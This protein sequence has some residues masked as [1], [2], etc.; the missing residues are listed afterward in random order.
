M[1]HTY[2]V[3]LPLG[4]KRYVA[5]GVANLIKHPGGLLLSSIFIPI[6]FRKQG[7]GSMLL[8]KVLEDA[9][10][11]GI[12][13]FL[14]ASSSGW[15]EDSQLVAWY[16]RYGFRMRNALMFERMPRVATEQGVING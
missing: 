15:M 13:L 9:D 4:S 14:H 12:T 6:A 3:E 2:H 10:Q 1:K 8:K 11:K 5:V 16:E 7:Y